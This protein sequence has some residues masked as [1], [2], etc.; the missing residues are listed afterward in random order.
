[1]ESGISG[2]KIDYGVVSGNQKKNFLE[3]GISLFLFEFQPGRWT[4]FP[5]VPVKDNYF[6]NN[7][8]VF[9]DPENIPES[10]FLFR[11]LLRLW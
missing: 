2:L 3:E 9:R 8:F 11:A 1:M 7:V 6:E 4:I 10:W 5:V